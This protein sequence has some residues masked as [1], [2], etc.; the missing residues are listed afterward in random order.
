MKGFLLTIVA[1]FIVGLLAIPSMVYSLFRYK[2]W[3][4]LNG[5]WYRV[6]VAI[7]QLGNTISKHLLNDFCIH[8][9]GL[10]FGNTDET[11][12]SVF[13]K[14]KEIGKLTSPGLFIANGLNWLEE[15]HVES[16]IEKDEQDDTKNW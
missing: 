3:K 4:S 10:L 7:D 8:N 15:D 5:H 6:A 16:S 2:T 1:L 11:A 14:N 9:G 12:S 13:G